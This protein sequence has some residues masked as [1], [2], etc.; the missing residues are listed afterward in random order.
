MSAFLR[1]NFTYSSRSLFKGGGAT[2]GLRNLGFHSSPLSLANRESPEPSPARQSPA[3]RGYD[4]PRVRGRRMKDTAIHQRSSVMDNADIR[5]E[6]RRNTK[7]TQPNGGNI[8]SLHL[9][10]GGNRRRRGAV[11]SPRPPQK[12]HPSFRLI[13][14]KKAPSRNKSEQGPGP[15]RIPPAR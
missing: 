10:I 13:M 12:R 9:I 7:H 2:A 6:N 1:P 3:A 14:Y 5:R 11:P 8:Y 15:R 4:A